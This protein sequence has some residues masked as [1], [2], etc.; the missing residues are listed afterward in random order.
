MGSQ[1]QVA[2]KKLQPQLAESDE[3]AHMFIYEA[4]R[5]LSL[6]HSNII[7][8]LDLGVLGREYFNVME[9]IYGQD[10]L[11]LLIRC[12]RLRIR[13]PPKLALFITWKL[14][15]ALE[16]A[17]EAK[18][19]RGKALKIKH[20]NISPSNLLLGYE[21]EVKL[22]DFGMAKIRRKERGSPSQT[23]RGKLGYLSPETVTG[24]RID[25][26]A[27]L[28]SAGILLFEMLAMNRLFKGSDE[29]EILMRVRDC[30]IDA[31]L[32]KL[33]D[34]P[35]ALLELLRSA[36]SRAPQGRP[37][38]A[39]EFLELLQEQLPAEELQQGRA[40][41]GR[42]M[43][44]IFAK[45]LEE[46]NA[47]QRE[48]ESWSQRRHLKTFSFRSK[49]KAQEG[50][51]TE[52]RIESN[53]ERF[54][55]PLQAP[56][57]AEFGGRFGRFDLPRL[58]YRYGACRVTGRLLIESEG[59]RKEIFWRSGRLERLSSNLRAELLGESL[60]AEHLLSRT[61]LKQ[62]LSESSQLDLSLGD[63]LLQSQLISAQDLF[64]VLSAQAESRLMEIFRWV[65]G[66]YAFFNGE[67]SESS[68]VPPELGTFPLINQGIRQG[69][70]LSELQDYFG[71]RHQKSLR[72]LKHRLLQPE[73][74]QLSTGE[75]RIW[76]A[77]K[78]VPLS[79][80]LRSLNSIPGVD[81]AALYSLLFLMERLEFICL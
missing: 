8:I 44:S 13:L 21:G 34:C 75:Q 64:K 20:Q 27:D 32:E 29:M 45:E 59:K 46:E 77:L 72:R 16:A 17:H 15:K 1:E 56:P 37:Q 57:E 68:S 66:E 10:L 36:L 35:E 58:L 31:A 67:L 71:E 50:E 78:E 76:G 47:E 28:F 54:E 3:I 23:L 22:G 25:H 30:K 39:T 52:P 40:K 11:K 5:V 19:S 69:Y 9:Y 41:L 43:R 60:V 73:Q 12:T 53:S 79:A 18:D 42:F 24:D 65:E 49:P 74:L 61:A 80:Q 33:S 7:Q 26:R 55:A 51:G 62:A 2:L 4:K 14:L 38:S 6:R 81:E 63:C 48:L 70:Q